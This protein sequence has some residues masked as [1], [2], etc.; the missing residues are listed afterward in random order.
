MACET[1]F[2]QYS[3]EKYSIKFEAE[4]FAV[5]EI[6]I[7][8]FWTAMQCNLVGVFIVCHSYCAYS[9]NQ[10]IRQQM[11][12]LKYNLWQMSKLLVPKHEGVWHLSW[13]VFYQVHLLIDTLD[14]FM[15]VWK[16]G[17]H[18]PDILS[19]NPEHYLVCQWY[20]FFIMKLVHV[21]CSQRHPQKYWK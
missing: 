5:T 9:Y 3:L 20:G 15:F 2:W 18:L 21:C 19:N 13:I 7:F 4:V 1:V 6:H 11:H 16:T 8:V 17:T 12:F 10:Y 14:V